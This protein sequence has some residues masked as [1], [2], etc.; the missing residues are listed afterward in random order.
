MN[1]RTAVIAEV[2]RRT[3]APIWGCKKAL[4]ASGWD[5]EQAC[6]SI[7]KTLHDSRGGRNGNSHDSHGMV[8]MYSHAFGRIG[9]LVEVACES[10]FVSR[11]LDFVKLVNAV[12]AHVAWANPQ[13]LERGAAGLGEVCLLD[14]PEMK[15]T[16]GQRTIGELVAELSHKTGEEIRIV[17]FARFEVGRPPSC[18]RANVHAL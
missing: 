14:Q 13:S 2:R 3:L 17:S 6:R 7:A 16:Q 10:G 1:D 12:A 11:S 4:E 18:C 8:G 15:E 9:V 5:V